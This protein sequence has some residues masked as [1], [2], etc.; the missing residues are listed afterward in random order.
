MSS[1]LAMTF[2]KF[3][4]LVYSIST[5]GMA[6]IEVCRTF[7]SYK[8]SIEMGIESKKYDMTKSCVIACGGRLMEGRLWY[9]LRGGRLTGESVGEGLQFFIFY[10]PKEELP[11]MLEICIRGYSFFNEFPVQVYEIRLCQK[12]QSS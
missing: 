12:T 7:G 4:G 3:L 6:S 8:I 5:S 1:I 11:Q 10:F 9:G 2:V